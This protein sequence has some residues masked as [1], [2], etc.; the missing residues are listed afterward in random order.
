M[1]MANSEPDPKTILVV[2][3]D[4]SVLSVIKCMLECGDYNVL[5]AHNAESALRMADREDL[6]ID[7]MLIDGLPNLRRP[8]LI[9]LVRVIDEKHVVGVELEIAA[10][11]ISD[12]HRIRLSTVL[13]NCKHLQP[14]RFRRH[15]ANHILDF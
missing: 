7:L 9:E 12:R 2:D 6:S 3:D 10:A 1:Y 15:T 11:V 4:L 13:E 14:A 8:V 5:M